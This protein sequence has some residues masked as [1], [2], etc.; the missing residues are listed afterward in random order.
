MGIHT[1]LRAFSGGEVPVVEGYT[2]VDMIRRHG[3]VNIANKT[4]LTTKWSRDKMFSI[5][6]LDRRAY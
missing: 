5:R 1:D 3:S 2:L 4:D 6:N